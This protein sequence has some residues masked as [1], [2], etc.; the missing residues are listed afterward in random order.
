MNRPLRTDSSPW[1]RQF[2]PWFL[3]AL[4]AA[5][6]IGSFVTL[7]IAIRHAD[8]V[9]SEPGFELSRFAEPRPLRSEE[10]PSSGA[11]EVPVPAPEVG[12][13]ATDPPPRSRP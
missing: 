2:W 11:A 13:I 4:P 12:E 10:D 8:T 5:S 6:V 1:Y 3:I 9:V 7:A